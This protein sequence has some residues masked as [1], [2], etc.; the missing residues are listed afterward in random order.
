VK[1]NQAA[2]KPSNFVV[3]RCSPAFF[4]H[5]SRSFGN[6]QDIPSLLVPCAAVT[7]TIEFKCQNNFNRGVSAEP[8]RLN[9]RKPVGRKKPD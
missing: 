3:A 5:F 7:K 8:R 6:G 4:T 1:G 2:Q 9:G